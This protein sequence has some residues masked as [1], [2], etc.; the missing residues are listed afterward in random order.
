VQVPPPPGGGAS[1]P[2]ARAVH[3]SPS[4]LVF[5]EGQPHGASLPLTCI[6]EGV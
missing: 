2:A 4:D 1:K 6:Q 3:D 5:E